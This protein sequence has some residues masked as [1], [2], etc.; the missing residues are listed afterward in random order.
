MRARAYSGASRWNIAPT[1][2]VPAAVIIIP[3]FI[4]FR[5]FGLIDSWAAL[6]IVNLSF[7]VMTRAAPQLNIFSLGFPMSMLFGLFIVWASSGNFLPRYDALALEAFALL[8]H[9]AGEP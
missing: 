1:Q 7:G 3:L 2:F 6:V 5:G 8:R 9:L 4:A